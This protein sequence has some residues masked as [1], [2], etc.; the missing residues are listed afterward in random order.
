MVIRHILQRLERAKPPNSPRLD[1]AVRSAEQT[2]EYLARRDPLA[3]IL[4]DPS[5]QNRQ[6]D[7]IKFLRTGNDLVE[8]LVDRAREV[9]VALR[10]RHAID[11]GC[12][13][14]RLSQALTLHFDRVTGIDIS[15]T[16]VSIAR[17]LH[18]CRPD[19]VFLL[20]RHPDLALL[21]NG[22]ADFVCSHITLQHLEPALATAYVRE[23]SRVVR[24]G[25]HVYFQLPSYR[26]PPAPA[27][28]TDHCRARI[29][30]PHPPHAMRPGGSQQVTALVRN[31][32]STPWRCPLS[33]GNHWRDHAGR[34]VQNDDGRTLLPMLAPGEATQ[35]TLTIKAPAQP[36]A[37]V[38][39]LD[40]VQEKVR[41][42]AQAGSEPA[43]V[44]LVVDDRAKI[45]E[46]RLPDAIG[47][48]LSTTADPAIP[49]E[50]H[51]IPREEVVDLAE[52]CG[53]RLLRCDGHLTD[54]IS[55]EYL[56][57]RT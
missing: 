15:E 45:Q 55:Y 6:S 41:W 49:L 40:V 28:P 47:R 19:L 17:D 43:R 30:L 52:S 51:P 14:G 46:R 56:F 11:F 8:R 2:W 33:L 9:G 13:V 39:E 32:S 48:H 5:T 35:C 18:G 26:L 37:Y 36:G 38:V 7:T 54:W 31:V 24:R 29:G 44:A 53:M 12:G 3:A 20:N 1:V 27:L 10:G 22:V 16:M 4:N 34:L 21:G 23:F 50:I 25:G 42:F 57:Q